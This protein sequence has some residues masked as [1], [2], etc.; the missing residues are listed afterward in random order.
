M[1]PLSRY[2]YLKWGPTMTNQRGCW[3]GLKILGDKWYRYSLISDLSISAIFDILQFI[4]LSYFVSPDWQHKSRNA[5]NVIN[6]PPPCLKKSWYIYQNM[7]WGARG[8]QP[9]PPAPPIPTSLKGSNNMTQWP[10]A[11]IAFQPLL[12]PCYWVLKKM[13]RRKARFQ[14]TKR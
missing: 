12:L 6:S 13:R 1:V 7:R 5:C 9:T 2:R 10:K 14:D 8:A 11:L 3:A 4:F